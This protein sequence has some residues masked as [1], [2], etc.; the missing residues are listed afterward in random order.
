MRRTLLVAAAA[1]AWV[2]ISAVPAS[3]HSVSG[4]SA[5]NL[6][7]NLRSVTPAVPGLKVKVVES[8]SRLEV[9]NK[10]GKEI[11]VIGYKDEPFLRIGPDGVFQN[12]LSTTTYISKTREGVEP[13]EFA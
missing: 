8:G 11:I 1:L 3:A 7:T 2:G 6:Q 5:T 10:S 12:K 4:V 9:S 13:P